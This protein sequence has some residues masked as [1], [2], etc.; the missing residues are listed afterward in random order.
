MIYL[1]ILNIKGALGLHFLSSAVSLQM[2]GLPRAIIVDSVNEKNPRH[3]RWF[4]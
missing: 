3:S 2:F 1:H 4:D